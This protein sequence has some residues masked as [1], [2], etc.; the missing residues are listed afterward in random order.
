MQKGPLH[1]ILSGSDLLIGFGTTAILEG[2]MMGKD[3]IHLE[4][5]ETRPVFEFTEATL[6]VKKL[7]ELAGTVKKILTDKKLQTQ[8]STKREKYLKK[9]F[10]RID[11]RAYERVAKL[12]K[13]FVK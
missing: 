8:L 5:L 12:I 6:R 4:M 1:Q 3:A 13:S 9:A 11:G 10:Y 2:L 7:D